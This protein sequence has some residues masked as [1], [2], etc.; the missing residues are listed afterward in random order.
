MKLTIADYNGK[1]ESC[2]FVQKVKKYVIKQKQVTI[3]E[4]IF[5]FPQ[6]NKF[7]I[8]RYLVKSRIKECVE[9]FKDDIA[10]ENIAIKKSNLILAEA[11]EISKKINRTT[12]SVLQT[13]QYLFDESFQS[14]SYRTTNSVMHEFLS[15][16]CK[17]ARFEETDFTNITK[18]F[19]FGY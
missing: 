15:S 9:Y 19:N 10:L 16:L 14:E 11:K 4:L 13:L 1:D 18:H 2:E 6:I 12:G 7:V 8:S 17:V 3:D 5:K